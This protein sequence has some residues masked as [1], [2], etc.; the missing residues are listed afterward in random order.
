MQDANIKITSVLSDVYG[1]TGM[2]ILHSLSEGVTDPVMLSNFLATNR[3]LVPKIPQ[4]KEA[5]N[6]Y[7]QPHH[8][9]LLQGY[10]DQ[11]RS[12]H[13]SMDKLDAEMHRI[14]EP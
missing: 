11:M 7:F 5:L 3:R 1:S 12:L 10:L 8:R 2:K 13:E 14:L 9:F 6:G 4:A